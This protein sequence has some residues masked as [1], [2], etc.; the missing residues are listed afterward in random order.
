M[1][2]ARSHEKAVCV[3]LALL[4]TAA[5]C[6][7]AEPQRSS[8]ATLHV[9]VHDPSGAV[10][11]GAR[12]EVTSA[13]GKSREMTTDGQGVATLSSLGAGRYA[14]TVGFPGFET[15]TIGDLR[16]KSGDTRR[17]VTLSIQK[18]DQ[19]VLVGRDPSTV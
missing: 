6:Q 9:V 11:P 18:L 7:A 2:R 8:S 16:V 10:I 12:V 14:L 5:M 17:D 19:S 15:K 3:F 1:R 4:G 13:D